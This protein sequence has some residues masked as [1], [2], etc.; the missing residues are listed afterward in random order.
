VDGPR[1][2]RTSGRA[3]VI[4][5]YKRQGSGRIFRRLRRDRDRGRF[6]DG[7][8]DRGEAAERGVAIAP[9]SGVG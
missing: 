5:P 1:G 8:R 7:I 9:E 6:R 4:R 3:N 2:A